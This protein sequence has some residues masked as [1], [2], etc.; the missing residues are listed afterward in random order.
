MFFKGKVNTSRFFPM[1][2]HEKSPEKPQY[3]MAT[4]P[5]ANPLILPYPPFS[6]KNFQNLHISINFEKVKPLKGG[7]GG[8]GGSNYVD[9]LITSRNSER[10]IIQSIRIAGGPPTRKKKWNQ[11]IQ[12]R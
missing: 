12:F 6:S 3:N 9:I 10:K 1:E 7:V 4:P 8:R 11:F 2:H 5:L